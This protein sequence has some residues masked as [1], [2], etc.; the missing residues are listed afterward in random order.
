M[1]DNYDPPDYE[2]IERE[3]WKDSQREVVQEVRSQT[4]RLIKRITTFISRFGYPQEDVFNKIE[5]DEMFAAHFAKEPRRT[6]LHE[7]IAAAWIK[8]LPWVNNF[9]VLPKSGDNSFKVTSDGNIVNSLRHLNIPGK[10]LDF[11]WTTGNKTFYAMHKYTKEGGG[12]Q[13][14]QYQEMV[15]LMKRFLHCRDEKL[16]LLIIIDGEYYQTNNSKRLHILQSHQRTQ[17]PRSYALTIGDLPKLL[18]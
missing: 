12:N 16:V 13:D 18:K 6:G 15:E 7:A 4:S 11:M 14:S 17:D 8:A 3:Q 10:S 2:A 5:N 1:S 9:K